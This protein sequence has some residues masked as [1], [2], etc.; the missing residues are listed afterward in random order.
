MFRTVRSSRVPLGSEVLASWAQ[1]GSSVAVALWEGGAAEIPTQA[2]LQQVLERSGDLILQ[3]QIPQ[4]QSSVNAPSVSTSWD[5]AAHRFAI[6]SLK[7][8]PEVL[9]RLT[10]DELR[11]LSQYIVQ[12]LNSYCKRQLSC[13]VASVHLFFLRGRDKHW[14][15]LY[16]GHLSTSR[17]ARFRRHKSFA[18]A[19]PCASAS[20]VR[21]HLPTPRPVAD[22]VRELRLQVEALVERQERFLQDTNAEQKRSSSSVR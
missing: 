6:K 16:F 1:P 2:A 15:F 10:S 9:G 11:H 5:R 12:E 4:L 8:K 21:E 18:P 3:Q 22:S 14:Y 13:R 7:S 20:P 17:C 19:P